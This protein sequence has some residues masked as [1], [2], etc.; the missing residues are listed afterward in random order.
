MAKTQKKLQNTLAQLVYEAEHG[1]GP[2]RVEEAR[3]H[4][5]QQR[6]IC[7]LTVHAIREPPALSTLLGAEVDDEEIEQ[8]EINHQRYYNMKDIGEDIPFITQS[9]TFGGLLSPFIRFFRPVDVPLSDPVSQHWQPYAS[10]LWSRLISILPRFI[11]RTVHSDS[12]GEV[13]LHEDGSTEFRSEQYRL[14]GSPTK[15]ADFDKQYHQKDIARH[16]RGVKEPTH[17]VSCTDSL[18][19]ALYFCHRAYCRKRTRDVF[20]YVVDTHKL[21]EPCMMMSMYCAVKAYAVRLRPVWLDKMF[22]YSS[23]TEYVCWDS[24]RASSVE[25]IDYAFLKASGKDSLNFDPLFRT[26]C[27]ELFPDLIAAAKFKDS[28]SNL[29]SKMYITPVERLDIERYKT[30][31]WVHQKGERMD[32]PIA[33]AKVLGP[34]MTDVQIQK[35]FNL[36]APTRTKPLCY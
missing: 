34:R 31:P 18:D 1:P 23:L 6:R 2:E 27:A 11:Y 32:P 19:Y 14:N 22:A 30:N 26:S 36:V 17:L 5:L 20:V 7:Q 21:L 24:L 25:K 13:V 9:R 16:L 10:R 3:Q 4:R 15:F 33:M 35:I 28:R 29:H 12:A 8:T